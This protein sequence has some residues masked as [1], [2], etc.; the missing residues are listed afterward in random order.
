MKTT[1]EKLVEKLLHDETSFFERE[2]VI[3]LL[4]K[5]KM[6]VKDS[7]TDNEK[8]TLSN[9]ISDKI[10]DFAGS[11]IFIIL[12]LSVLILWLVLNIL[13]AANAFDPYPF[14]LLNLFLSCVAAI[15]APIILMSQKRQEQRDRIKANNDYWVNL[16]AE[17]IIEDLH[18]KLEA[19]GDAQDKILSIIENRQDPNL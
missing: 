12:F 14:I 18:K 19:V 7:Y 1:N 3:D 17:I 15:Q 13:M 16:K 6:S 11:W 2:Q 10:A 4:L 8:Q 9:R 5:R